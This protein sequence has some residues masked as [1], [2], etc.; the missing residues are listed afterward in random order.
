MCH[1]RNLEELKSLEE[2]A[3]QS[4]LGVWSQ[5]DPKLHVRSL[6]LAMSLEEA[7]EF[8]NP[9]ARHK[10]NSVLRVM[11]VLVCQAMEIFWKYRFDVYFLNY[12]VS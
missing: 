8:A 6:A 12:R 4:G 1:C 5:D 2:Q 7:K 3:K 9:S 11:D 10:G